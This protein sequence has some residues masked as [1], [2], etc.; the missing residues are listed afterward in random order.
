MSKDDYRF[1]DKDPVI[2]VI[3]TEMQRFGTLNHNQIAR[4]AYG[5]GVSPSTIHNWLFGDVRRPQSLSTRFVLQEL[6]VQIKYVREDGT[7]IRQP[8]PQLISKAEQ[9]KILKADREREK[10][11][12]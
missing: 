7:T 3:R 5:S 1:I 12:E 11:R 4:I 6:G 8:E 2:D 9:A 10:E